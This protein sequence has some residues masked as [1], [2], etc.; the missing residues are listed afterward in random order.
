M[1]KQKEF[2][3]GKI[4]GLLALTLVGVLVL[5]LVF[6]GIYS[7]TYRE[8]FDATIEGNGYVTAKGKSLYDGQGNALR[9]IGTN[10][11]ALFVPEGWLTV[12]SIGYDE[13]KGDYKETPLDEV[14]E[15]LE[16]NPNNFTQAEID[17]LW[18]TYYV[19]WWTDADFEN[20]ASLGMNTIRLPFPYTLLY[21]G[22]TYEELTL[23]E[24]A[25]YWLDW[26]LQG[27]A[28]NDLYCILDMHVTVGTQSWYEHSGSTQKCDLFRLEIC[29]QKTAD[30][31]KAI[32]QH[33]MVDQ[34]DLGKYIAAFDIMNEPAGVTGSTGKVEWDVMD[35]VYDAIRSVDDKHV[36]CME[37]CWEFNNLPDPEDYDWE[38]VLYQYHW[39][40]WWE[41]LPD[42]IFRLYKDLSLPGANYDVPVYI[43]EFNFF[44]RNNDTWPQIWTDYLNMFDR[45]NYSWTTWSAKATTPGWWSTSWGLYNYAMNIPDGQFKVDLTTATYEQIYNE[46]EKIDQYQW[47]KGPINDFLA[48]YIEQHYDANGQVK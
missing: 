23:R 36:I 15:A 40:N 46:F 6:V 3:T 25:F 38:N 29:Q 47:E 35:I 18:Q 11:G 17:Q 41:F 26:F 12:Y 1:A 4:I 7:A 44:D 24:D 19:N 42:S 27:C 21:E 32:A 10:A 31:W 22:E 48:E 13:G 14:M 8:K 45:R 28:D 16:S 5:Y 34:P 9:L 33:Y 30:L 43:G 37:G 39:Y 2:S 20:I